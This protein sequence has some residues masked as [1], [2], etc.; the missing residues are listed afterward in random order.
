MLRSS[1]CFCSACALL[2]TA[3]SAHAQLKL[4]PYPVADSAQ[5]EDVFRP[6]PE[7]LQQLLKQKA[8][9]DEQAGSAA[10]AIV[11]EDVVTEKVAPA[12]AKAEGP[13]ASHQGA[14][15]AVTDEVI[16]KEIADADSNSAEDAQSYM[17]A[18]PE[19]TTPAK[20]AF[21][22]TQKAAPAVEPAPVVEA[23]ASGTAAAPQ[24][25][26][27]VPVP[28]VE[29]DMATAHRQPTYLGARGRAH[30]LQLDHVTVIV[31]EPASAQLAPMPRPVIAAAPAP[32]PVSA[33]APA[34]QAIGAVPVQAA[35]E[36]APIVEP[37]PVASPS[38]VVDRKAQLS[39]LD[40]EVAALDGQAYES[41]TPAQM[42]EKA[43]SRGVQTLDQHVVPPAIDDA[44]KRL[45]ATEDIQVNDLPDGRGMIESAKGNDAEADIVIIEDV[46]AVAVVAKGETEIEAEL[47]QLED[48][49]LQ[50]TMPQE[51]SSQDG[52]DLSPQK[53]PVEGVKVSESQRVYYDEGNVKDIWGAHRMA[54]AQSMPQ[55]LIPVLKEPAAW[56]AQEGDDVYKTISEWAKQAGVDLI[57]DSAFFPDVHRDFTQSGAFEDAVSALLEDYKAL[58]A[59]VLGTLYV[60]PASGVKTLVVQSKDR[61]S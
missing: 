26:T 44:P 35:T 29:Q 36:Q 19:K 15:K 16:Q 54:Q 46:D 57:W 43:M 22:A 17:R 6:S 25:V 5:T 28:E 30:S 49:L 27:Q 31:N 41:F 20:H 9:R 2:F 40:S 10:K 4:N 32:V 11:V 50:E 21:M 8:Q 48:P 42:Q 37:M 51:V 52:A 56:Q 3:S 24:V 55:N 53:A 1:L 47:T 33:L 60:D 58:N 39:P 59:G 61:V 45:A 34:P 18:V 14:V 13:V 23:T 12:L 38:M 7:V